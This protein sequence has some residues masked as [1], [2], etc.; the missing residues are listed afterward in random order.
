SDQP[1]VGQ[2]AQRNTER[3]K[4]V[5]ASYHS[6]DLPDI[7]EIKPIPAR[8]PHAAVRSDERLE[9]AGLPGT[10]THDV[11]DLNLQPSEISSPCGFGDRSSLYLKTH[12]YVVDDEQR[13]RFDKDADRGRISTAPPK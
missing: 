6:A 4:V 13:V 8:V 10:A 11:P 2:V 3:T 1:A 12:R 7:A 9:A 5:E